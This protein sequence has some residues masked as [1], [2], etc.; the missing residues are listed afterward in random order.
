MCSQ[1][2]ATNR[3]LALRDK[4]NEI[5]D[6][7]S[8]DNSDKESE[9]TVLESNKESIGIDETLEINS[10]VLEPDN[11]EVLGINNNEDLD[12]DNDAN[13]NNALKINNHHDN[14][15]SSL[16]P[17]KTFDK[18]CIFCYTKGHWAQKCLM[19]P[20]RYKDKCY[21]CWRGGHFLKFCFRNDKAPWMNNEKYKNFVKIVHE[22]RKLVSFLT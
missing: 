18:I 16:F 21:R 17:P 7:N 20:E 15:L 12:I 1:I 11:N 9:T 10:E 3:I 19:I 14:N 22:R 13:G 6:Y 8:Q 5:T 4:S 2:I